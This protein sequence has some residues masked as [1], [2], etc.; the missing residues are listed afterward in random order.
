MDAPQQ[1][2]TGAGQKGL[3]PF[4]SQEDMDL[5]FEDIQLM[6]GTGNIHKQRK[7]TSLEETVRRNAVKILQLKEQE[8]E[9]ERELEELKRSMGSMEKNRELESLPELELQQ[10]MERQMKRQRWM[11]KELQER[12]ASIKMKEMKQKEQELKKQRMKQQKEMEREL[13]QRKKEME[14]ELEQRKKEMERELEDRKKEMERELEERK[15]ENEREMFQKKRSEKEKRLNDVARR[16]EGRTKDSTVGGKVEAITRKTKI[17]RKKEAKK[18]KHSHI[19]LVCEVDKGREITKVDE[20]NEQKKEWRGRKERRETEEKKPRESLEQEPVKQKDKVLLQEPVKQKDEVLLQ[21]PVQ[22]REKDLLQEPVQQREDLQQ[23]EKQGKGDLKDGRKRERLRRMFAPV[24]NWFR[25]ENGA[26]RRGFGGRRKANKISI[27]EKKENPD[28]KNKQNNLH[29]L[30]WPVSPNREGL[31]I[32]V[33][34]LHPGAEPKEEIGAFTPSTADSTKNSTPQNN[35]EEQEINGAP[36]EP[37]PQPQAFSEPQEEKQGKEDLK[38]GREREL[39]M[40]ETRQEHMAREQQPMRERLRRMFAPVQNWF[41]S[42]NG[43]QN[44]GFGGRR[45]KNKISIGE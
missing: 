23:L 10:G 19:Q 36:E 18:E 30:S 2:W 25:S 41:V 38:D 7:I 27:E 21:E 44:R 5:R 26:Q 4:H 8:D 43:A 24:Q 17:E 22:Q 14:R 15:N 16:L 1:P 20:M 3:L 9:L 42:Q 39:K 40:Q 11:E 28:L 32:S 6:M 35:V 45:M 13:E 34:P 37:S 31:L 29:S 33:K 12:E